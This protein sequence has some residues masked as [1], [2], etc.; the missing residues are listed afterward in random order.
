MPATAAKVDR[1]G[2]VMFNTLYGQGPRGVNA[3]RAGVSFTTDADMRRDQSRGGQQGQAAE[4]RAQ[5]PLRVSG[6]SVRLCS[7]AAVLH[8]RP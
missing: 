2:I 5:P 8:H 4:T 7:R 6:P 1:A 3:V